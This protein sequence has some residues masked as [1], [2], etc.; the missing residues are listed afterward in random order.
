MRPFPNR[1]VGMVPAMGP[2]R[3][4]MLQRTPL[5]L[6]P[7]QFPSLEHLDDCVRRAHARLELVE[8]LSPRTRAWVRDSYTA[9]RRRL[10]GDSGDTATLL[11][12]DLRRQVHVLEEWVGAMHEQGLARST[13][14]NYWRGVRLLFG[15]VAAEDGM[16]N[17]L[18]YVRAPH[19]GVTP[20]RFLTPQAAE[21]VVRFVRNDPSVTP[22]LRSRNTA[23]F[24]VMLLAGLRRAEALGLLIEDVDFDAGVIRV[25]HG[26]GRYGGKPRTVPM[27]PQLA[28]ICT[29]YAQARKRAGTAVPAFFL[30]T[31]GTVALSETTVMRLFRRVSRRTG[32]HVSPHRLRH[33]FCTLLSVSGV[34]DRLAREAMGHA[35]YTTLQRYQH[36]YEGELAAELSAKLRLD[37][38]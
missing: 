37:L 8:R 38:G 34:S 2:M 26:K 1:A 36:V 16:L 35:D 5:A 33:T 19:P 13:V 21:T 10:E 20:P 25:R 22:A 12:G 27:T 30:G 3:R 32:I 6:L 15:R 17:P 11:G 31:R 24:A 28:S 14:N 18:E 23:L 7:F 4:A 29:A 9:L